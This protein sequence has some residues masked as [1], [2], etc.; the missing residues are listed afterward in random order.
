MHIIK[1]ITLAIGMLLLFANNITAQ[2]NFFQPANRDLPAA[3]EVTKNIKKIRVFRLDKAGMRAYLL[4]SPLESQKNGPSLPLEIPLPNGKTETFGMMETPILSPAIAAQHP[5]IKTY[6]GIGQSD[7]KAAIR[8]TFTSSG[9]N[10]VLL[11]VQG[12][13]VYF[14][15]YSNESSDLYFAYFAKDA[16]SPLGQAANRACGVGVDEDFSE[17]FPN[18]PVQERNNTGPTLTTYRLAF[19]ADGE[20]TIRHGGVTSAFNIVV[21]YVSRMSLLFRTELCIDFEMINGDE[22]IYADPD[23]DPY[24]NVETDMIDENQVSIDGLIGSAGYD[25]S[26]VLGYDAAYGSGGG[27]AY[28]GSVCKDDTK[29]GGAS[30]EGDA[31][32]AQVF[33]DQLVFHEVGHMFNMTHSYNS[34]IPVCTSRTAATSVEPGSGA[35]IMS[36]GFT[37]GTDDYTE[38][39]VEGPILRFHTV[40]YSQ[41]VAYV[42]SQGCGTETST[43]NMPPVVTMPSNYTIPKSTPFTLTGSATDPDDAPALLT[44][45]WEGTNIGATAQGGTVPTSELT[46]LTKSPFFR[47]YEPTSSSSRTFPI[48]ERILD[49]SNY[50]IG[51][52]LPAPAS[53]TIATTHRMTV[54]DNYSLGGGVTFGTVT[55]TVN[56]SIGPF[57]ITSDLAGSYPA[58]SSPVIHW[59]VLGT[60]A[61]TSNVKIS[62]ST[63]GG[64]SFP[65][66]L[67]ASA[68]NDGVQAVTLPNIQT[69]TARIKVE[70]VGNIFFDISNIDFEISAPLPVE[71]LRFEVT[72]KDKNDAF[73]RWETATETNSDGYEIEMG[74]DNA[75]FTKMGFVKGHGTTSAASQYS[76]VVSDLSPDVYYFR[77]KMRDTDGSFS[78]SPVQILYVGTGKENAHVYPNPSTNGEFAIE[79]IESNSEEIKLK[80]INSIGQVII[81][82]TFVNDNSPLRT[83]INAPGVYDLVI[84]LDNGVTIVKRVVVL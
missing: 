16:I 24:S 34:S 29:A 82:S 10:A 15:K 76:F 35:T 52:K 83:Q 14:E 42:A 31:P 45:D 75:T 32:Y 57:L 47:S 8:L 84:T 58:L 70:A 50:G 60:N 9:L 79:L 78:Y 63:D 44:Y 81:S 80:V 65:T 33:F 6:T 21:G 46:D 67:L 12:D 56:G 69:T 30:I 66:V 77:L 71:L 40:N 43:S 28:R 55:V 72:L 61:A 19:A 22:L 37:C 49:G 7:K 39:T 25:V 23:N 3:A 41:A 48:L 11:N 54:R 20:F 17:L 59:D 26:H 68:T 18:V 38:S 64:F 27:V 4:N 74:K 73:L 53:G 2:S 51:D 62:L 36:Y 5:E 13:A 1:N